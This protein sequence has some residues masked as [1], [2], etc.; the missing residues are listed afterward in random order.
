MKLEQSQ[1]DDDTEIEALLRE[2][3]A[4][5]Q[6][7]FAAAEEVRRAVHQEWLTVVAQRKRRRRIATFGIAASFALMMAVASWVLRSSVPSSEL[8]TVVAYVD[9][10]AQFQPSAQG[11]MERLSVGNALPVG[12]VLLT[13]GSTRVALEYGTAVSMRVDR[14]SKIERVGG[15]RFRLSA[16]AVYIDADPKAD[17]HEL[18]VE[19]PAGDV[20]HLGTQYQVRQSNGLIEI[21]IREG[22]VEI[23]KPDRSALASAGELLRINAEG[24]IDRQAI[25]AQDPQWDWAEQTTPPF[26]IDDRTLAEFLEWVG[27]ETGRQVIYASPEAQTIAQTLKLRGSIEGLDPDTALSA[28]LSTTEFVRYD[29]SDNLIGVQLARADQR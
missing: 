26:S 3:G 18:I 4:G 2:V 20:R 8:Q 11:S 19:T 13:D 15:N 28:V 12:G 23:T 1:P 24:E 7:P 10:A 21:G 5:N 29:T 14:A 25:S 27:R 16:G 9:G 6:I 22:R 17:E